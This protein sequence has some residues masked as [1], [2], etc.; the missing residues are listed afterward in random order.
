MKKYRFTTMIAVLISALLLTGFSAFG[1]VQADAP[2]EGTYTMFAMFNEGYTVRT[3]ALGMSYVLVLTEDGKGSMTMDGDTMG[4]AEWTPINQAATMMD[5]NAAESVIT[6][7]LDDES[8]CTCAVRKGILELDVMGNGEM[9]LLYAQEGADYSAYAPL[10]MEEFL[11][12]K[13]EDEFKVPESNTRLYMLW[14]TMDPEAGIH[15]NYERRPGYIDTVQVLDVHGKG[16]RFYSSKTSSFTGF[17]GTS[18]SVT[19]AEDGKVYSL[20]PETRTAMLITEIYIETLKERIMLMDDV[21]Q[22]MFVNLRNGGGTA[23]MREVNG[24]TYEAEIFPA[25]GDSPEAAFCFTPDGTFTYY[26][27]GAP[28]YAPELGETVYTIRSIDGQV[29]TSLLDLSGYQVR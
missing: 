11:R 26:I 7:L 27:E 24:V 20:E 18:T 28:S 23:G 13:K 4:V 17:S 1:A 22:A 5:G 3:D 6:V 2:V 10:S 29:D 21:Y 19:Y 8:K 25:S 12:K 15:M 14:K 9:F 16:N